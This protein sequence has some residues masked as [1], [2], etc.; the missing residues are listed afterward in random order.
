MKTNVQF[1]VGATFKKRLEK[2][3]KKESQSLS[4]WII[5]ACED[6]LN[7]DSSPCSVKGIELLHD[8]KTISVWMESGL[9]ESIDAIWPGKR[10]VWLIDACLS[11]L[12]NTR[13]YQVHEF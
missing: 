8:L 3:A 6:R 9:V 7:E 11:R 10:N 2:A 1:N 4:A 12:G 13:T 5:A